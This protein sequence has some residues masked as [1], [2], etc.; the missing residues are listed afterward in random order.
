MPTHP[1]R[2]AVV[3]DLDG[4]LVNTVPLIVASYQHAFATVLD[5]QVP[6]SRIL[7]WIGRPLIEG[8]REESPEHAQELYE[9]YSRWNLAHTQELL[10]TFS[11]ALEMV[12][13]LRA[14]GTRVAVATSKRAEPARTALDLA[15]FGDTVE[16][17]IAMEDTTRHKPHP[18][19][20]LAACARLGVQP[21]QAFYVGDAVVDIQAGRAAGT[22][23]A[24]VTWGAGT[25][26][27]LRAVQPDVLADSPEDLLAALTRG[28]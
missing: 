9:E 28:D 14:S 21:Q 16:V 19:P 27:D 17:V 25:A 15:G 22:A 2:P 4:T 10:R 18:D 13:A 26:E 6:E 11:G 8:M 12:T 1:L 23:T 7:P 20:V 3:F 24:A 5:R